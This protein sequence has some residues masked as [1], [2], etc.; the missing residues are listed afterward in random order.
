MRGI[1]TGKFEEDVWPHQ[2]GA[3]GEIQQIELPIDRFDPKYPRLSPQPQG[4]EVNDI[5]AVTIG[6]DAG[7]RVHLVEILPPE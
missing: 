4:L 5:Y 3:P 6:E 1:Y 7:L 2:L